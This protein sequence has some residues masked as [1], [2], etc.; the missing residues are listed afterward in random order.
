MFTWL[1]KVIGWVEELF[2]DFMPFFGQL[3]WKYKEQS[4]AGSYSEILYVVFIQ[5]SYFSLLHVVIC[6]LRPCSGF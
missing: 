2:I 3:F 5:T 1:Q 6:Q 4:W